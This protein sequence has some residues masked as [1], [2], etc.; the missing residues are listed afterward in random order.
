MEALGISV[1]LVEA[2]LFVIP[3]PADAFD[4]LVCLSVLEHV[5][6][7]DEAFD[8]LGRVLR[9]GGVAVIGFPVRNPL[10]DRLFRMLGYDPREIHPSSHTDIIAAAQR[11]SKF[12][13]D[14]R[15]QIPPLLPRSLAA[16]ISLRLN[17]R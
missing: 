9:P 1:H 12:Q 5:T 13:L 8:E 4:A 10:T 14:R 2:S 11:T 7:L 16:Y 15:R 3:F 6:E 17:A